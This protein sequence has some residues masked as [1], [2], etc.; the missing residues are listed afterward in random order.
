MRYIIVV[1]ILLLLYSCG[2]ESASGTVVDVNSGSIAGELQYE[3]HLYTEMVEVYLYGDGDSLLAVDTV[4]GGIYQFDSLVPGTYRVQPALKDGVLALAKAQ[5]FSVDSGDVLLGD[6]NVLPLKTR[7]FELLPVDTLPLTIRSFFL[8]F[9]TVEK[10][11]LNP[12]CFTLYFSELEPSS[13]FGIDYSYGGVDMP[14]KMYLEIDDEPLFALSTS[15]RDFAVQNYALI[16]K[17]GLTSSETPVRI[18]FSDTGSAYEHLQKVGRLVVTG[19][20]K[21]TISFG[22]EVTDSSLLFEYEQSYEANQSYT[23]EVSLYDTLSGAQ[24]FMGTTSFDVPSGAVVDL[25]IVLE[26]YVE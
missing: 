17:T 6:F 11:T 25:P 9:G 22:M 8:D 26:P 18:H 23:F 24:Q 19:K 5:S 20:S 1:Y 7:A 14:A 16:T 2:S 21:D 15:S 13:S 4:T 10:D 12:L 3:N